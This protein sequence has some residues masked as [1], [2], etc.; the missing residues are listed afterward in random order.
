M[1]VAP[2]AGLAQRPQTDRRPCGSRGSPRVAR[3]GRSGGVRRRRPG[4]AAAVRDRRHRRRRRHRRGVLD[5]G[6]SADRPGRRAPGRPGHARRRR[7]RGML[8][9]ARRPLV[10]PTTR[11]GTTPPSAGARG[12][13]HR[14]RPVAAPGHDGEVT[15]ASVQPGSPAAAAGVAPATCSCCVGS[16]PV[17]GDESSRRSAP[18]PARR[19]RLAMSRSRVRRGDAPSH[20]SITLTAHRA[21]SDDDVTVD[22]AVGRRPA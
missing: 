2:W 4:D 18:G 19:G 22:A 15:V 11:R 1:P 5:A 3:P 8:A 16:V 14:R 12:P 9:R 13:L 20:G 7:S 10:A 17:T 6:R 21:V